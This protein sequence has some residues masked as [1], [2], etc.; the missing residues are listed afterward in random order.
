MISYLKIFQKKTNFF[1][2][3][4]LLLLLTFL[5]AGESKGAGKDELVYT[6]TQGDNLLNITERYLDGGFKHWKSLVKM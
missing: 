1:C 5:W 3:F 2:Y 6:L 4:S